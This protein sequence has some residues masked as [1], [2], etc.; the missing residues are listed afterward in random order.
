MT[1]LFI[2]ILLGA[3]LFVAG[4]LDDSPGLQLLGVFVAIAGIVGLAK[5]NK[6]LLNRFKRNKDFD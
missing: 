1:Y 5:D 3:F 2:L 6:K 4:E